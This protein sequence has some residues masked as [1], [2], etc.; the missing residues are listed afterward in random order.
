MAA[1]T[2]RVGISQK[3]STAANRHNKLS[4]QGKT[5]AMINSSHPDHEGVGTGVLTA[6]LLHLHLGSEDSTNFV[7]AGFEGH[8]PM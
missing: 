6:D 8:H 3:Y 7:M 1:S 5:T 4:K 2:W